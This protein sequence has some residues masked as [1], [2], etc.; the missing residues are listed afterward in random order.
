M[1]TRKI[2]DPNLKMNNDTGFGTNAESYGGR[3]IN[4]DGSFNLRKEGMPYLRRYSI[5]YNMLTHPL[6]RLARVI[7]AFSS[8]ST[9]HFA[10]IYLVIG[11]NQLQGVIA[12]TPWGKFKEAF[13]F[14]T[15]TFTTVG[16]GR[17]NPV[18]GAANL[19]AAIE[20]LCGFLSFAVA[21]GLMYGRFSRPH[22][23]LSSVKKR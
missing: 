18:G 11:L 7:L 1:A 10:M 4:K 5:F 14:S 20:A 15:E 6:W 13:F 19:V 3:F 12:S 8:S 9:W 21:T 22:A 16:Y 2:I 17:V 23:S